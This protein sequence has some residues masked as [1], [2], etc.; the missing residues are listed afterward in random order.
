MAADLQL[1]KSAHGEQHGE[2]GI[3]Q[4]AITAVGG[5]HPSTSQSL[6]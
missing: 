6:D 1:E 5:E 3:A 4:L 2:R